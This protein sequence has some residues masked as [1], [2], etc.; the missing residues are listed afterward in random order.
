MENMITIKLSNETLE[1]IEKGHLPAKDI[2]EIILTSGNFL[3]F[4]IKDIKGDL[5]KEN[6]Y[7]QLAIDKI[8]NDDEKNIKKA[9]IKGENLILEF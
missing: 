4:K 8:Y 6:V 3:H 9:Y 5:T 1:K 2:I 7:N